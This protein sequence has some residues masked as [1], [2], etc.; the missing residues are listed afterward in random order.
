MGFV[1]IV[2]VN[3]AMDYIDNIEVTNGNIYKR[4]TYLVPHIFLK[5]LSTVVSNRRA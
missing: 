4:G 2:L 3:V 5:V 1:G